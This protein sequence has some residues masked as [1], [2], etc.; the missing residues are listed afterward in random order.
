[1]A[2]SAPSAPTPRSDPQKPRSQSTA[3]SNVAPPTESDVPDVVLHA[4]GCAIGVHL[5]VLK[6][7]CPWFY[8]QLR[9]LR[10]LPQKQGGAFTLRVLEG[11][12]LQMLLG[13]RQRTDACPLRD[14]KSLRLDYVHCVAHR[15][16][17]WIR[18]ESSEER[19]R[20]SMQDSPDITQRRKRLR[21]DL[22]AARCGGG[23]EN[24]PPATQI[25][26]VQKPRARSLF[27]KEA[28]LNSLTLAIFER[29]QAVMHV[30]IEGAGVGAVV[31]A[32]EYIY[33][34]KVRLIDEQQAMQ[35]VR[36]GQWLGMRKTM[37]YYCLVVAIRRVTTA[38]W[39]EML[40]AASSLEDKVMRGV[41]C[42]DLLAYLRSL[43]PNMYYQAL[44][45]MRCVYI[46]RLKHH[47]TLVR[48]VVGLINSIRLV[49]FWRN[50]VDGLSKWLCYRFRVQQPPSL[51]AIHRHFAPDWEPYKEISFEADLMP[52]TVEFLTV[53]EF[54]KFILQ[55]RVDVTDRRPIKWRVIKSSSKQLLDSEP[56][57]LNGPADLDNDPQ[58][59][60]RG[61]LKV[62]YL[63][64]LPSHKKVVHK[65]SIQYQHCYNSYSRWHDLV[66][67]WPPTLAG[68]ASAIQPEG[69][70]KA[71]FVGK[72]F[73]W[74]DPVCS[75]YHFLLQTT[76]FYS[77]PH[78]A[79]TELSDLM[80]VS[81]MQRLPL[82]TLVLVLR[83]DRLRIPYGERTLL[84]CLN[85]LVFGNNFSYLGSSQQT[86]HDFNG[87]AKDVIRLYKCVRW[88]FV[89]LDDIIGTLRRSPR[90]LKFYELIE[91]GMEDTYK[92][93]PRRPPW[94]WRKYRP[95]YMKSETHLVEF[96]IE[97]GDNKLSPEYFP[98][99]DSSILT[100][101]AVYWAPPRS[102][103]E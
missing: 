8:K 91:K 54:G 15:K 23:D 10:H 53:L 34:F 51:R 65:V 3:S 76:L 84:R 28:E 9:Q 57:K 12:E 45:D 89:P 18:L 26:V 35:A 19:A 73:I 63:R 80:V 46:S 20:T 39:M 5:S 29:Q 86:Q 82:D 75:M 47:D 90:Q 41:L 21:Q 78:G 13:E 24:Q 99:E 56:D 71:S 50:L 59:W 25:V 6:L 81:E 49:E 17:D 79:S 11:A 70:G 69:M 30:G 16:C 92:H 72:F 33:R 42:D 22:E 96:R 55:L 36:L 58:F 7:R 2:A 68:S 64:D 43:G 1:M 44:T 66:K 31:T 97:A 52:D 98:S 88:C 27:T 4:D 32:V 95:A 83:S 94:G 62:K 74:G 14:R 93:F 103:S 38:T 87:R 60:I 67:P 48:S 85:K 100:P 61:Q 102:Q 40:L 77:A 37:L 101:S